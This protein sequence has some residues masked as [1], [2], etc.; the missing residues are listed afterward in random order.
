MV[1]HLL[2]QVCLS[3]SEFLCVRPIDRNAM[4][5]KID[6]NRIKEEKQSVLYLNY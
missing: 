4:M 5:N 3:L 1:H 6:V 2:V